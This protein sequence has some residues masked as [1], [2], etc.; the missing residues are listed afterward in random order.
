MTK[1]INFTRGGEYLQNCDR[2]GQA[3][4]FRQR[5]PKKTGAEYARGSFIT[6]SAFNPM[7]QGWQREALERKKTEVGDFIGIVIVP[8]EHALHDVVVRVDPEQQRPDFALN[9]DTSGFVFDVK[10]KVYDSGTQEFLEDI[11]PKT[12]LSGITLEG[13]TFKRSAVA[14]EEHGYVLETGKYA[15]IGL[16]V[17]GLPEGDEAPISEITNVIYVGGHVTDWDI[18][19]N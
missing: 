12:P 17:K 6:G 16:E 2:L 19:S 18:P 8:Q 7:T 13:Y 1:Y 3:V 11:E 14:P 5:P 9:I 15:I 10:I 4:D